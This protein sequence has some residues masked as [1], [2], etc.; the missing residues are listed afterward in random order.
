MTKVYKFLYTIIQ[1]IKISYYQASRVTRQLNKIF[2]VIEPIKQ[3]KSC[4]SGDIHK[5][6]RN[7][8]GFPI[9]LGEY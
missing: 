9:D 1:I 5:V 2:R 7:S 3:K 6:C 8:H 4:D